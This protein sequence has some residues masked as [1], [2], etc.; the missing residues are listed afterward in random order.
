MIR[1]AIKKY[2]ADPAKI[3]SAGSSSGGMMTNVLLATYPDIFKAG[4]SFSG[5][6]VGCWDGPS[7]NPLG[8]ADCPSRGQKHTP[9]AWGDIARKAYPGYTGPRP[10]MQVWHG[11][12]DTAVAYLNLEDQ[13]DQWSDV[14]GVEWTKNVTNSPG[15]NYT[16]MVYGDGAKLVG[17]SAVGVGHMVPFHDEDVLKFFGLM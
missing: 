17:Y 15:P 13:L 16:Q 4:A 6:P 10:S 12:T 5:S 2:D 14:L 7:A 8:G 11:T 9:K 3:F 1:Y